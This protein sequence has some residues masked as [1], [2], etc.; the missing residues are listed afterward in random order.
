MAGCFDGDGAAAL[1]RSIYGLLLVANLQPGRSCRRALSRFGL[2]PSR[3]VLGLFSPSNLLLIAPRSQRN[4][5]SHLSSIIVGSSLSL[6]AVVTLPHFRT[7]QVFSSPLSCHVAVAATR[8]RSAPSSACAPAAR[9]VASARS[10]ATRRG[11]AAATA[12]AAASPATAACSSSGSPSLPA[13]AWPLGG[14][15]AGP[16]VGRPVL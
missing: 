4:P 10:S 2:E 7:A 16:S 14:R 5:H 1:S 13:A 9:R 11:R 15:G 12:A 3:P 6:S 8:P